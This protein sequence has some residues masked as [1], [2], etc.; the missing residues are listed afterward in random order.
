VPQPDH[1]PMQCE[2]A[3]PQ[4]VHGAET[5]GSRPAGA[6]EQGQRRHAG[7]GR[8][9]GRAGVRRRRTYEH[10]ASTLANAADG[11][12]AAPIE[13]CSANV[14]TSLDWSPPLARLSA[15]AMRACKVERGCDATLEP[16]AAL[17]P[18]GP[19]AGRQ[20]SRLPGWQDDP[21]YDCFRFQHAP[22]SSSS[23]R[24]CSCAGIADVPGRASQGLEPTS[25]SGRVGSTPT[26]GTCAD[27][28]RVS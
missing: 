14:A 1:A 17:G 7:G 4:G 27:L 8:V 21:A 23:L 11:W 12:T 10:D 18:D 28:V 19:T 16:V 9:G 20:P 22:A 26:S 25:P 2:A 13:P 15:A 24:R 6:A 3:S 5:V